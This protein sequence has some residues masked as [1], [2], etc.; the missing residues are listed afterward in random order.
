MKCRIVALMTL[1]HNQTIFFIY[2]SCLQVFNTIRWYVFWVCVF[3]IVQGF[4]VNGVVNA[5]ITT[6]E[7]RFDLPSS[8]SGLIASSNDFL[9]LF[10]VLLISFYGSERHKPKLIGIGVIVL[11]LGSFIFSI[12]H[13]PPD[14]YDY[15]GAGRP[16]VSSIIFINFVYQK[17]KDFN[18]T[19]HFLLNLELN[20][21]LLVI[22]LNPCLNIYTYKY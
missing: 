5:I 4:I 7:K 11:G 16:S 10:L 17:E 8:K 20:F 12:P 9:A 2:F 21:L 19:V 1:E 15:G 3:S 13:F 14:L 18:P 22:F 6:L